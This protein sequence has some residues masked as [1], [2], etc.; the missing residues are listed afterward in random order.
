VDV[1]VVIVIAGFLVSLATGVITGLKGKYG[2]LAAGLLIGLFW[3]I[4]AIRLAK[5]ASWWAKRFYGE[6]KMRLARERFASA[7]AP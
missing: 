6:E 2:F 5:P 1:G 4:G 7:S 3:I